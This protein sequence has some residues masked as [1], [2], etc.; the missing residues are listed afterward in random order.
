MSKKPGV[1]SVVDAFYKKHG[2]CCAG[3]DWWRYYNSMVGDCTKH[4][5][6]QASERTATLD[7]RGCSLSPGAGHIM[8]R[9]DH[10]CGDFQDQ[11]KGENT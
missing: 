9:R 11:E 10:V 5:P 7:M 8:T 1:Q 2:P 3:C 4:A 6:V